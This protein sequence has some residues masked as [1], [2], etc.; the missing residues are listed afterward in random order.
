M[1]VA[2][3][4]NEVW[5]IVKDNCNRNVVMSL[6][7]GIFKVLLKYT[8]VLVSQSPESQAV[9]K[10]CQFL[11][12]TKGK[13][14]VIDVYLREWSLD[15]KIIRAVHYELPPGTCSLIPCRTV[16]NGM[17]PGHLHESSIIFIGRCTLHRSFNHL[18]PV[19]SFV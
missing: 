2:P 4:A 15:M 10:G 3:S 16:G 13:Q 8:R 17:N 1:T 12:T 7:Q 19:S 18:E 11:C 6:D 14:E 9:T 5:H